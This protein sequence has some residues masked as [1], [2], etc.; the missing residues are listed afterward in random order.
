LNMLVRTLA[1][2]LA[3]TAPDAICVALHP[4]TV[5]TELSAPFQQGVR[6]DALFS[7]A[8]AAEHLLRVMDCLTPAQSGGCFAWNGE[9]IVP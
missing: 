7:A 5:D 2:E 1:I 6:P 8:T 4:G 3:R 9:R